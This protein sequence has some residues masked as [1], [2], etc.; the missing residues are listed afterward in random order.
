MRNS[1]V[2]TILLLAVCHPTT[3]FYSQHLCACIRSFHT[4]SNQPLYLQCQ[5]QLQLGDDCDCKIL[6][7]Y[8]SAVMVVQTWNNDN[9]M[10]SFCIVTTDTETFAKHVF[11]SM[12]M[13]DEAFIMLVSVNSTP[14]WMAEII[15]A[16]TTVRF[17][18]VSAAYCLLYLKPKLQALNR[19][20][21]T[22]EARQ[23]ASTSM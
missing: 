3:L 18:N 5:M 8:A 2:R 19:W 1:E 12:T 10:H 13:S 14:W 6:D 21:E 7:H 4:Y 11:L 20:T 23:Y 22:D 9:N 15:G 17:C 16:E